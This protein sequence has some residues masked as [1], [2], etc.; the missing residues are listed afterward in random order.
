MLGCS[1]STVLACEQVL[2]TGAS[3]KTGALVVQQLLKY[4]EVF[5]VRVAVRSDKV[6]DFMV[7]SESIVTSQT[8]FEL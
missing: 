7:V 5:D 3:G 6:L 4:P 8:V 1:S 2:V